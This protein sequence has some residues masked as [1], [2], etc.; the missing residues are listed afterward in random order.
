[1]RISDWSSDGCSSDLALGIGFLWAI[2]GA[3]VGGAIE[4]VLNILP[5][6]DLFL[7]VDIWPAALAIPAFFAGLAFAVVLTITAGRRPDERRVGTECVSTC[8]SRWS[9]SP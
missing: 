5:G 3:F 2:G 6:P 4:L 1:M 9:P 7:G 8:R